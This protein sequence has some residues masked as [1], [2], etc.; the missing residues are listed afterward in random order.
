MFA[1][2]SVPTRAR[3]ASRRGLG[4]IVQELLPTK[5]QK[6]KRNTL[7]FE[8]PT[9]LNTKMAALWIDRQLLWQTNTI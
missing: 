2:N 5:R 3:G 6:E 9:V 1:R 8:F 4:N 7:R